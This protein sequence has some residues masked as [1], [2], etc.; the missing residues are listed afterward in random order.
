MISD[1]YSFYWKLQILPPSDALLLFQHGDSRAD[2]HTIGSSSPTDSIRA[3]YGPGVARELIAISAT[4][5]DP[6]GST[7]KMSGLISSANYSSK[8]TVMVLF[9]NG[10]YIPLRY[11]AFCSHSAN[12]L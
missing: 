9:I 12:L 2:V 4:D 11:T 5:D 7:F 6:A 10:M 1:M 3:V 8:R